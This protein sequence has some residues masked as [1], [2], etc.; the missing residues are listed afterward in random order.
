ML[1]P[2]I[3]VDPNAFTTV[4]G[5]VSGDIKL[6]VGSYLARSLGCNDLTTGKKFTLLLLIDTNILSYSVP[7][8]GLPVPIKIKTD[9]GFAIL[10]NQLPICNF[11]QDVISCSQSID[12]NLY[13]IKNVKSPTNKCDTINAAYADHIK[14]KTITGII[15]NIAM[16]DHNLFTFPAAKA[17]ACGKIICEM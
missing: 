1:P 16:T 6:N 3:Y 8:S 10:I 4:G 11:R 12:I 5:V 7:D 14:Y 9:G 17:F 13:L 15:P 2:R